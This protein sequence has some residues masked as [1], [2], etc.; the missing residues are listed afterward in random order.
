M[1]TLEIVNRNGYP[2]GYEYEV[3]GTNRCF[4]RWQLKEIK[5]W[6]IDNGIDGA[7]YPGMGVLGF[8][9]EEDRTM[10]LLRW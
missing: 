6:I 3:K 7:F 10:F 2:L 8:A 5:C 1:S 4:D 9:R